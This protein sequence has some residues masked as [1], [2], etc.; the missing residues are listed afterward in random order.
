MV[1]MPNHP[2]YPAAHSSI[3]SAVAEILTVF[4]GTDQIGVDIRGFDPAG[5][6]GNSN[7]ARHFD[8]AARL[9]EEI[10]HARLWAG[11]HY[12]GSSEAGVALGRNVSAYDLARAFR[13]IR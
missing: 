11:V 7:A 2:E 13:A 4:L 6:L 5:A 8:T 1:G 10:V 12:R 9:R 3:T